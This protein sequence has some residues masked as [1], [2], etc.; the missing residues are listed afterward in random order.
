MKTHPANKPPQ[1]IQPS[2]FAPSDGIFEMDGGGRIAL[3]LEDCFGRMRDLAE[4]SI[5]VVVTSPPYNLG[6][7]YG[8]YDDRISREKYLDWL[9][10]WAV[11]VS[12]VLGRG[13][14]LFLN[15][16]GKPKNPWGPMEAAFRFRKH[17]ELQNT[18]HWIKSIAIDKSGNGD[19]HGLT[20]DINV[21]HIKPINSRRYVS[22]AH[23]Y[24]FHFTKHG[25]V[26]LDRKAIGV[27]YKHKSNITRWKSS[28]TDSRCRG[29]TWFI[30]YKTIVSRDRERPH[31]ASFPPRLAEMCIK[32]HGVS[33]VRTVMDP[34]M[35]LGNTAVACVELGKSCI[36]Y[37]IDPEYWSTSCEQVGEAILRRY[38]PGADSSGEV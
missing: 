14:S 27:A 1:G 34:F 8:T 25:D 19:D 36:G 33:E 31:P 26:N 15:I 22:D 24:V 3:H 17:F 37:E 18:I 32:L 13:G 12:R 38:G 7:K 4:A 28:G 16:G 10:E 2:L 21:G 23:E 5:D 6:I 35:G 11:E 9:E 20:Q 30:P 29:N